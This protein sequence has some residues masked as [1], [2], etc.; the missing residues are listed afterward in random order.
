MD[1]NNN[2]NSH[3]PELVLHNNTTTTT[4]TATDNNNKTDSISDN[5]DPLSTTTTTNTSSNKITDIGILCVSPGLHIGDNKMF[6]TLKESESIKKNQKATISNLTNKNNSN[7]NNNN[8]TFIDSSTFI[9]DKNGVY[10][11]PINNNSNS[12][13]KNQLKRNKIPTPLILNNNINNNIKFNST[14]T[15]TI[16]SAPPNLLKNSKFIKKKNNKFKRP[17]IKYVGHSTRLSS[18]IL[19]SP[20]QSALPHPYL[21]PYYPYPPPYPTYNNPFFNINPYQQPPPL[22]SYPFFQKKNN[23]SKQFT[24]H[25]SIP[26]DIHD[27]IPPNISTDE[28]EDDDEYTQLA[29]EDDEDPIHNHHNILDPSRRAS[30]LTTTSSSS[31]AY[32][33]PMINNINTV[34]NN[35]NI[36][37]GEIQIMNEIFKFEIPSHMSKNN[38]NDHHLDKK[39]FLSICDKIFDESLMLSKKNKHNK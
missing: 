34:N 7:I 32:Y 4:A 25:N 35:P 29:I 8:K 24:H 30:T 6:S 36:L 21:Y 19:K 15:N 14:T 22:T 18:S 26:N 10:K 27:S 2:S 11:I 23:T 5:I 16:K 33:N 38:N 12:V 31:S 3:S 9:S 13:K 39:I 37:L 20:Y 17:R 1:S 28:D